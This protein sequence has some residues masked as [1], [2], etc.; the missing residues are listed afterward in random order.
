MGVVPFPL[1]PISK[2]A[3]L[4]ERK[5][6]FESCKKELELYSATSAV[7]KVFKWLRSLKH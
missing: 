1:V 3:T 5:S 6:A 2:N 4:E 7:K